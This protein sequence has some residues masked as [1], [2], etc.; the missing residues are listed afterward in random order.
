MSEAD[1]AYKKVIPYLKSI[2]FQDGSI[3]GYGRVPVQIGRKVVWADIVCNIYL[4]NNSKLPFIVI[5]VKD[6]S[7]SNVEFAIPQAESYAQ[8]LGAPYFCCTNGNVYKWYMT[9][10]AQGEHIPLAT[11]PAL[12][13]K[14]YLVK[15]DKIYISAY[16]YEAISNYEASMS[17]RGR[18]FKDTKSHHDTTE[19]LNKLLWDNNAL[20]NKHQAIDIFN[21]NTMQ[22]RGKS[23]LLAN[24]DKGYS[25][26]IYLLNHLKDN[27][28]PIE[29]R[30]TDCIGVNSK[31]GISAGGI[32]FVTQV[33][34]GLYPNEYTVIEQNAINAMLRFKL[35]DIFFSV[36]NAKEYI[37][38][39][40][41][42]N[43]LFKYFKNPL[44]YNLSY[45]HN[46]LWHYERE[47]IVNKTWD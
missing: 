38:F 6:D 4:P 41:I 42:C 7:D 36:E 25:E 34:A 14:S 9:G 8:R 19:E 46:F 12:P 24:I 28:I 26:F 1:I 35:I 45:V 11:K 15:P 21:K 18:I 44:N 47:F 16:L 33:L 31:F 32:F 17:K 39:N 5:E 2:G 37:Y 29:E 27:S 20:Q 13:S 3:D 23:Q 43:E 22:S 10:A 40:N 30:I